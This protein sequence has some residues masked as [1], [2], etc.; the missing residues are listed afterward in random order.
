MFKHGGAGSGSLGTKTVSQTA[1]GGSW[2]QAMV[3]RGVPGCLSIGVD[4]EFIFAGEGAV[5]TRSQS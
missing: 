1:T 4:V 3:F 2:G 5:A